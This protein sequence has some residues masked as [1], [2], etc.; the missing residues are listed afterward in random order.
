MWKKDD[1]LISNNRYHSYEEPGGLCKLIIRNPISKDFGTFSC[2]ASSDDDIYIVA[3]TIKEKDFLSS[4]TSEY[5][6]NSQSDANSYS[7]LDSKSYSFGDTDSDSYRII[8]RAGSSFK[9]NKRKPF[10]TTLLHDRTVSENSS[11]R[12]ICNVLADCDTQIVWMKNN[13][14]LSSLSSKYQ[15]HFHNG[16]ATL[17]IFSTQVE[18]SGHYACVARNSYGE[19]FSYAQLK[20]YKGYDATPQ[21]PIFTRYIKGIHFI[22]FMFSFFSEITLSQF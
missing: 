22:C 2:H 6:S 19:T 13:I 7:P 1:R 3:T 16:L 20:V 18:D 11:I 21:S 17:E 10:F 8:G 12:L 15:M 14:E 5:G 9:D 4:K